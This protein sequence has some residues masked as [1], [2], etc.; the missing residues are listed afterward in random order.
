MPDEVFYARFR[1]VSIG[2][3]SDLLRARTR[4]QESGRETNLEQF[5]DISKSL[6]F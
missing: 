5:K 2:S 1:L 4:I 6:S 3:I